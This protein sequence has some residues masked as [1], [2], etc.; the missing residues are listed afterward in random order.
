MTEASSA[1]EEK[2]AYLAR[3]REKKVI[4]S[5]VLCYLQEQMLKVARHTHIHH[6]TVILH[7]NVFICCNRMFVSSLMIEA[8][9]VD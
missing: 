2:M 4:Q 1:V 3:I 9:D 7:C 8:V 5:V 6:L